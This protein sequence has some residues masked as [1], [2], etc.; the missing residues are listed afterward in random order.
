ME[1]RFKICKPEIVD[2]SLLKK[3]VL[4]LERGITKNQE[5]RIKYSENP[6]K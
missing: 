3:L 2:A 5:L 6:E 1:I 4:K